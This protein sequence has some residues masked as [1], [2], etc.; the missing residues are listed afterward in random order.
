MMTGKCQEDV[1]FHC[2]L[3]QDRTE[4][5]LSN[6]DKYFPVVCLRHNNAYKINEISDYPSQ[7]LRPEVLKC[8]L[9]FY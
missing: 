8:G 6:F 7:H 3:Q 2:H 9:E 4:S 1:R 5:N